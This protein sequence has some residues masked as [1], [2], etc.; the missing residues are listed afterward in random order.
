MG[1]SE[2]TAKEK[3]NR[4]MKLVRSD[5]NIQE[6]QEFIAQSGVDVNIRDKIG[7]TALMNAAQDGFHKC[8]NYITCMQELM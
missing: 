6:L 8:V 3:S 1:K 5:N 4:L 2:A 7:R